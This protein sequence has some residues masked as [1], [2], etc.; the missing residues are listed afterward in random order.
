[1]AEIP[2]SLSEV[3]QEATP[4]PYRVPAERNKTIR[5]ARRWEGFL[6]RKSKAAL[7]SA[8]GATREETRGPARDFLYWMRNLMARQRRARHQEQLHQEIRE[9]QQNL[10]AYMDMARFA[11]D[12]AVQKESDSPKKQAA[13]RRTLTERWRNAFRKSPPAPGA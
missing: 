9:G 2:P 7:P 3:N 13:V 6:R 12:M 5:A 1:M 11:V 4:G 10:Q 8:E